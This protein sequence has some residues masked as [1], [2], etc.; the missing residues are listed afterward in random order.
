MSEVASNPYSTNSTL[1]GSSLLATRLYARP[2]RANLV[3]RPRIARLLDSGLSAPLTL[4]SA[5]AGFGKTTLLA[6]WLQERPQRSGWL[7]LDGADNDPARFLS[8]LIAALQGAVP[9]VADD[10]LA[11]LRDLQPPAAEEVVAALVNE[12]AAAPDPVVLVL[13]DYH[14]ITSPAVHGAVAYLLEHLPPSLHLVIATRSDPPIP[15]ARLRARG[16]VVEVRADDLRFTADE[17][18]AFLSQTMGLA[19]SSDQ[20]A[21]LDERCEGW[22]AG[23]QMAAL[24][25]RGREDVDGFVQAFAGTH[26]FIMDYL[27]EEVLG[28]EPEEV[29]AF[30]LQTAILTRLSGPLCD[31]VT[32]TSGGQEMLEGLERRNLFVVPLDDERRWYRY[33]HLFADLLQARLHRSGP[34]PVAGLYARAGEWCEREGLVAEAVGY[35]LAARDYQRAARLIAGYWP[36]AAA[37]GEVEIVW[38]WLSALPADVVRNSAPLGAAY[39]WVLW[40][41]GQMDLIEEHLAD[42]ERAAS[43]LA[44]PDGPGP[45]DEDQAVVPALLAALRSTVARYHE[46]YGAASAHAERALALAPGNLPPLADARLRAL[47]LMT[48]ASAYDGAGDLEKAAEAQAETTRCA[49]LGKSASGL[50]GSIYR[51]S[52]LLRVLGRLREAVEACRE[53]LRFVEEQGMARLPAAGILHVV[54][55]ELLLEHND[56]E[57][58]ESHLSRGAELG[59]WSGRMDAARNAAPALARLRLARHDVGGALA[60]VDEAEAALG[61]QVPALARAGLLALRAT[62]LLRHGSLSEAAQCAEGAVRLAGGDRG[63]TGEAV[64]LAACRVRLAQCT[65]GEA[66]AELSCSLAVAEGSGRLGT[67]LE[68]RILRSLALARRGDAEAAHAD[69]QRALALA[70]PQGYVRLF[71]DEGE[72]LARLVAELRELGELRGERGLREQR[73]ASELQGSGE[74]REPT[75][76]Q[77][78]SRAYLDRLLSAFALTKAA[79]PFSPL[80]S[81]APVSS[82]SPL[83]SPLLEPLSERELQVLRLMAEGLT[84]QQIAARLIVALGTVKAHVHNISGKLAALNRAHA[85]ARARELG[86]L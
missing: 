22:I 61:E 38:S 54:M 47:I 75:G 35:A 53:A 49:R 73:G 7:T 21:A 41:R 64:A 56:L 6:A 86:L 28:R 34:G 70:E 83:S 67:A 12:L 30:L 60:A 40:L 57:G 65:P 27:L 42:A 8:Y 11:P 24:S 14:A 85:V 77:A 9:G 5:P 13:D 78:P 45:R 3:P 1:R 2:S 39:C 69:L 44:A 80:S 16:L 58:A 15:I 32:G 37:N 55:G 20:V 48:L 79:R 31:A 23:L 84:N 59:R 52:G 26:R 76:A 63:Q 66:V 82:V 46:D 4:V 50:A 51:M 10:L 18:A 19:L 36:V 71:L 43:E 29:Q 25:L 81:S 17:A 72:P 74:R 62:I 68:L 33:H